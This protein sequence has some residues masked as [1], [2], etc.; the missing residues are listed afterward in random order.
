LLERVAQAY[1]TVE[2]SSCWKAV[3]TCCACKICLT[4]APARSSGAPSRRMGVRSVKLDQRVAA[5]RQ[6]LR[7]NAATP[8][9]Q[10]LLSAKMMG[11]WPSGA[12]LVLSLDRD[13]PA[14]E[15]DPVHNNNFLY[16]VDDPKGLRCPS[17]AGIFRGT[18]GEKDPIVGPNDGTGTFTI[19]RQ[20]VRR[21]IGGLPLFVVNRGG[22]YCFTPGLRALAWLAELDT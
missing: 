22:E 21:R 5:F 4:A 13:D 16:Y 17:G 15:R 6:Y 14:L 12:P 11:R 1:P 10:T 8:K 2:G 9:E 3:I 18:P 20:P 7:A 19:P